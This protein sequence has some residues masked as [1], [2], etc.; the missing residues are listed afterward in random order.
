MADTERLIVQLSADFRQFQKEFAKANGVATKSFN[1]MQAAARK[2]DRV[3]DNVGRNMA[4]SLTVPLASIGGALAIREVQRYADTWTSAG[5]KIAA[6]GSIVGMQGRSLEEIRDLADQSRSGFD[7]TFNLYSRMLRSAGRVADSEEDIARATLITNKAFKAGGAA[8]SEMAAG[9]LQLSQ[10][11][12]GGMLQGDELRSVRENAPILA[13]SIA[14]Y[15][16][17]TIGGLKK[18]GAEGKLTSDK[19]FKAILAAGDDVE[20]AF[21]TTNATIEES[22]VKVQNALIQYIGQADQSAGATV[23]LR[24]GLGA[25]ADNMDT[26]A[27]TTLKVAAV[28]A[29][30]LV[31]RA[32][33]GAATSLVVTGK[34]LRDFIVIAR[35][36]QGLSGLATALGG[37]SVAAGPIALILGG[38]AALAVTHFAAEAQEAAAR[39]ERVNAELERMGIAAK[40]AA[41]NLNDAADAQSRLASAKDLAD[42]EGNVRDFAGELS[43][44]TDQFNSLVA[45]FQAPAFSS[46]ST[47]EP[48]QDAAADLARELAETI[49]QFKRGEISA[50]E[51]ETELDAVARAMP[52]W[53]SDIAQITAL[54]SRINELTLGLRQANAELD[55]QVNGPSRGPQTPRG[56]LGRGR[57]AYQAKVGIGSE[58]ISEA[59]RLLALTK[60]QRDVK[61]EIAQIKEEVASR[62]GVISDAEAERLAQLRVAAK[63]TPSTKE[64]P[65]Q[66]FEGT[67]ADQEQQN[68]NLREQVALQSSL[69]PLL[70]DYGYAITRLTTKQQL[71]NDLAKN[72]LELTP[73]REAAI[74]S[75]ADGFARATEEAARLAE[76]QDEAKQSMLDWFDLGKTASRG[77][78]DDLIE[79]KTAAEALGNVFSKLGSKLIDLGLNGLFG[80]GSGS[81]PFGL[82]GKLFGFADGGIAAYGRPKAFASGG[83][84]SSAAIFGEAGPEAAVPLP[85]GRRIPVDLRIPTPANDNVGAMSISVPISIDA[86]GAD[87]A[88]LARL[89]QSLVQLKSELPLRI[90][91]EVSGA[92][93]TW[94]VRR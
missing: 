82:I 76:A 19:I 20:A 31:G 8:A 2:T 59:E 81:N 88:G 75:L 36:A 43:A 47:F 64:T 90:R 9:I 77:F 30:A 12:A 67:L 65:E 6:A 83:V 42:A 73:E 34:A 26:V 28:I 16:G 56:D 53:A 5:N 38:A 49:A 3:F 21:A 86:T 11:L 33:L 45:L 93:R 92:G 44:V 13:Q 41:D 48:G 54:V 1:R 46:G 91:A 39:S 14:E 66:K 60:E 69:N 72:D 70:N 52:D 85:D 74:D 7:E 87:A 50:S 55:V 78:I 15:F 4:R 25:L 68:K 84:S 10:G 37:L 27:D 80:T 40:E 24:Q 63:S 51:L 57:R 22:I 89:E 23:A 18:L 71:L 17:T 32:L 94:L 61:A 79:G 62:G 29:G 58:Y 35:S